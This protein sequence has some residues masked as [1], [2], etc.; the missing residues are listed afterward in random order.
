MSLKMIT[1]LNFKC[2]NVSRMNSVFIHIYVG[3][4]EMS[5]LWK[6]L[7]KMR[8][9]WRI[10]IHWRTNN[11]GVFGSTKKL[12]IIR[13]R[14]VF[15]RS[16]DYIVFQITCYIIIENIHVFTF[17]PRICLIDAKWPTSSKVFMIAP[18]I[19]AYKTVNKK[20]S[21]LF[22]IRS[23]FNRVNIQRVM[24]IRNL[25]GKM[26]TQRCWK[27]TPGIYST[28]LGLNFQRRKSTRDSIFNVENEP[29]VNFQ[30]GSKYFV[31]PAA[32]NQIKMFKIC[33]NCFFI[34]RT[35]YRSEIHEYF[36][37]DLKNGDPVSQ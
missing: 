31:T 17:L 26:Q 5:L 37:Y 25:G 16:V 11:V 13:L 10:W 23:I 3:T 12:S 15:L 18:K 34:K 21:E 32:S 30:P 4:K 8:E 36:G 33:S 24:V 6:D 20:N 7:G 27:M 2:W 19:F 35:E 9:D 22:S 28:T 29:R 14:D 1:L